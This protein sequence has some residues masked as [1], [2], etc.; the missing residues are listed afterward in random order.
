MK[1]IYLFKNRKITEFFTMVDN[2]DFYVLKN[3]K[4]RIYKNHLACINLLSI[5]QKGLK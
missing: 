5:P 4:W 1:K 2:E 3:M